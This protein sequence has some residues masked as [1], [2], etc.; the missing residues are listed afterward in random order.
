MSVDER[1]C[2]ARAI[3]RVT[4]TLEHG[5]WVR[6][7]GS[8]PWAADQA[9]SLNLAETRT[10]LQYNQALILRPDDH[11]AFGQVA[12]ELSRQSTSEWHE[13]LQPVFQSTNDA[14]AAFLKMSTA[15]P[16]GVPDWSNSSRV[17]IMRDA[18][19]CTTPDK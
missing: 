15:A 19:H 9:S 17:T 6:P 14:E 7:A 11:D 5:G 3:R 8:I 13:K 16:D 10:S 2:L 12:A 1:S 18:V 4:S